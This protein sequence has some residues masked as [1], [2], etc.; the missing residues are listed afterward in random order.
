MKLFRLFLLGSVV[1]TPSTL[2]WAG[3][4]PLDQENVPPFHSLNVVHKKSS[5]QADQPKTKKTKIRKSKSKRA[6][7]RRHYEKEK[8][9][10]LPA[11][12]SPQQQPPRTTERTDQGQPEMGVSP[13]VQT[14]PI[15]EDLNP[16]MTEDVSLLSARI[17]RLQE[18]L[19]TAHK[20]VDVK[21]IIKTY[22][23]FTSLNF[24]AEAWKSYRATHAIYQWPRQDDKQAVGGDLF[25]PKWTYEWADSFAQANFLKRKDMLQ[26]FAIG[27]KCHHPVSQYYFVDTLQDIRSGFLD[28]AMPES[29]YQLYQQAFEDLQ[30]CTGHPAACYI[31]GWNYWHSPY[32]LNDFDNKKALDLHIKGRDLRNQFQA[33]EIQNTYGD[34]P[35]FGFKK[36]T[37]KDYMEVARQGYGPAYLKSVELEED[38]D[39]KIRILT[40][41]VEGGYPTAHIEM[42]YLYS[43]KKDT[44]AKYKCYEAA[45]QAG[46]SEGY[47]ALGKTYVGDVMSTSRGKIE[48]LSTEQ[49]ERAEHFFM[50]AGKAQNPEGWDHLAQLYIELLNYGPVEDKESNVRKLYE[51]LEKGIALG[52]A[53]AYHTAAYSFPKE[54]PHL[55]RTYGLPPQDLRTR[56][57]F[58]EFLKNKS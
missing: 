32:L 46:I 5:S 58:E 28:I 21:G 45:A 48:A 27:A 6:A 23:D 39:A 18:E 14:S 54:L 53:R 43:M 1:A 37:V 35:V 41:A 38:F 17:I 52:S 33:L 20:E 7:A 47:I 30:Q 57:M 49:I 22:N 13:Q 15:L 55:I 51:A 44:A 36:A 40:A 11:S 3:T 50:F 56:L 31:L 16:M 8:M 19:K 25:F 2:V 24:P 34:N 9:A 42:G 4:G 12:S 10:L 26:A 29:F